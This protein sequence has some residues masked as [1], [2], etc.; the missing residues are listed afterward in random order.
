MPRPKL[1]SDDEILTIA[2]QVLV[3]KG[4]AAFTLTDVA[5]AVGVSRAAIIQRFENKA[6]L[7]RKVMERSTQ[8]VRDY[9]AGLAIVEGVGALREMLS[10]LIGGLGSGE[11]FAGYLLLEW[12]DVHDDEL[13]RL[14]RERNRLVREAIEMRLPTSETRKVQASLI[15][16][17][18]QG[19]TMQW[20]IEQD[21]PLNAFVL[22]Q[23]ERLIESLF[24]EG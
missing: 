21:G 13:N 1:H 5:Q 10:D 19:A 16:A 23:T 17:V 22:M 20:L 24:P 6:T 9:F 2:Q 18:I 7:H 15:Q 8:E 4:P 11:G 14:A 3:A 12:S